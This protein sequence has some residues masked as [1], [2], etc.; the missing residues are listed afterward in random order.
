MNSNTRLLGI[1]AVLVV[2]TVANSSWGA[3]VQDVIAAWEAR[4]E[5]LHSI[6]FVY[7]GVV[8]TPEGFMDPLAIG[9]PQVPEQSMGGTCQGTLL[10]D[11]DNNLIRREHESPI[12]AATADR[13]LQQHTQFETAFFNGS[14]SKFFLDA[15][16][17]QHLGPAANG[18]SQPELYV[19]GEKRSR[20]LFE[21]PHN[22]LLASVGAICPACPAGE[23]RPNQ[24]SPEYDESMFALEDVVSV[25]GSRYLVIRTTLSAAP[26]RYFEYEVLE[27]DPTQI[28]AI[29]CFLPNGQL[30]ISSTID[31]QE[32][33]H[34]AF[35]KEWTAVKFHFSTGRPQVYKMKL[36]EIAFNPAV[37][38]S[39]F[40]IDPPPGTRVYDATRPVE[41]REYVVGAEGQPALPIREDTLQQEQARSRLWTYGTLAAIAIVAV[42]LIY[43]QRMTG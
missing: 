14:R 36:D 13:S 41:D 12:L 7:S 30:L 20:L 5:K 24:L 8:A 29:R 15:P 6:Q 9:G 39:D 28:R 37:Q 34:G 38:T 4:R 23:V 22:A 26:N 11:L 2:G 31:Y 18:V 21:V 3:S 33:E 35:P 1:Q 42:G 19:Y 10:F 17:V 40:D 27:I 43:R 32:T 16:A 25:D